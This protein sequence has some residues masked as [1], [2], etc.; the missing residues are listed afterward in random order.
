MRWE[1]ALGP[2][3]SQGLPPEETTG[4]AGDYLC[5]ERPAGP[6][7]AGICIFEKAVLPYRNTVRSF[8]LSP[9]RYWD[10]EK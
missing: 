5:E 7:P 6:E 1:K 10:S 8:S 2:L 3:R 4:G 9:Y